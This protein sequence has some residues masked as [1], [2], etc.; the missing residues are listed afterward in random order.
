MKTSGRN[1]RDE[2]GDPGYLCVDS[3]MKGIVDARALGTA[4]ELGLI[5]NLVEN[6]T[7]T[8][9]Q[10]EKGPGADDKGARFLL[11]L[12]VRN[13]V[14]EEENGRFSLSPQFVEALRYRDL[15]E[16]KLQFA[17]LVLPD[18][19][20]LFPALI[21]RPEQFFRNAQ[22]FRLFSYDRSLSYT[23]ENYEM[24]KRWVRITTTLTK[25]EAPVCMKH[26]DFGKYRRILDV[27]G[28]SGELVLRLCK[29][30]P[31]LSATVFDLPLVC[32]IGR[33][34]ILPEPEA[35]RITFVRGN[36]LRDVLPGQFDAVIFKSVLHDWPEREARELI[37]R[38]GE[39]LLPGGTMIIFERGPLEVRTGQ[40]PYSL[41]PFLLFFR[42]FRSPGLY[43]EHLAALGF[44]DITVKRIELE[45]PFY[46]TAATR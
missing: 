44:R 11:D 39:S 26:H 2:G 16:A 31:H 21:N 37:G 34:H 33:E 7:V 22:V 45:T 42:S 36:A 13:Q 20:N 14:I 12:L 35:S 41:I 8:L 28:N 5:D 9:D 32:D 3:F 19:L 27:G 1:R 30:Y 4:F 46:L 18:L 6:G 40:L 29:R 10:V 23:L 43:E 25:Y 24:T 15:M 38:A 17:D